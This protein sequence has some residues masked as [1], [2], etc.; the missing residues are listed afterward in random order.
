[1]YSSDDYASLI[2]FD[3]A[4][5][6]TPVSLSEKEVLLT[7]ELEETTERMK[8]D[9]ANKLE[10]DTS[11]TTIAGFDFAS[12]GRMTSVVYILIVASLLAAVIAVLFKAVQ[13]E[14]DFNKKRRE[15]LESRKKK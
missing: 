10:K 6:P 1:M 15:K 12:M 9:S 14:P 11:S 13:P 3:L 2:A 5:L 7:F 4:A 8:L